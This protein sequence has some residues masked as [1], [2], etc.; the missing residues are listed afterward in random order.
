MGAPVRVTASLEFK[1]VTSRNGITNYWPRRDASC[2]VVHELPVIVVG[3][4]D[5]RNNFEEFLQNW[6]V[7][8]IVCNKI[9]CYANQ[10][11]ILNHLIFEKMYIAFTIS[12]CGECFK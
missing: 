9:E 3:H 5:V 11:K 6:R 12:L 4:V 2:G 7:L 8:E 1:E 10:I